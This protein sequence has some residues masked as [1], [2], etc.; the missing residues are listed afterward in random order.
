MESISVGVDIGSAAIKV[1]VLSG[2]GQ[3]MH[4]AYV[5]HHYRVRETLRILWRQ[6]MA[7]VREGALHLAFTGKGAAE[8]SSALQIPFVN[9]VQAE[10]E[11]LRRFHPEVD[12]A[13][14]LGGEDARMMYFERN[15]EMDLR[16]NRKCA[17]GT[18]TFLAHMA[19]FFGVD[20][21]ALNALA[22]NGIHLYPIA[23]RC[24]VYA[25]TDIQALMN[26]GVGK[27]D[28]AASIFQAVV[29]QVLSDLA[30][31]RLIQGKLA[32]LGG[33]FAFMPALR[34]SFLQTIGISSADVLPVTH[35]ELYCAWGAA[36][37]G[38]E[39]AP[40]AWQ[41]VKRL[42]DQ[43][44]LQEVAAERLEP[45]FPDMAAYDSFRCYYQ[46]FRLP[47]RPMPQ[48][49]ARLWLGM[50]AGSTTIKL[51]LVDEEGQIC[52]EDY[53]KNEADALE[54]AKTMLLAMYK[55]LPAGISIAASGIT[56][57]GEAFL[58]Q[59]FQID[60]GE[61][62]TVAHL[63]GARFFCPEVTD[64]LDIGGQDMKYIRVRKGSIQKIVLNGS[65]ASGCGLFLETFAE[66][67]GL[68]MDEFVKKAVH[69]PYCQDLG[70]HCTVLMNSK[71]HQVQN[72][73]VD[74]GGLISGLC[75][76]VV[77]NALY[78]V[79]RLDSIEEL[80]SHI[81][82][83]GG[84]FQNDAVLRAFETLVGHPV[85][86]PNGSGI[87][88][89]YGMALLTKKRMPE[90]ARSKMLSADE[91]RKLS[92]RE[93]SSRCP[94]CGNHCLLQKKTFSNGHCFIVGNRCSYGERLLAK[95][96]F[97][98]RKVLNLYEWEKNQLLQSSKV[99]PS[100]EKT[101][102]IPAVLGR[103]EDM[104]YWK[105]FWQTLGYRVILSAFDAA[106]LGK[107]TVT[108]PHGIYCYPCRLAH[109]HL[110]YFLEQ[111][112]PDGI[113][114]PVIKGGK[115]E[116]DIDEATHAAYGDV[117]AEQMKE[118]ISAA[119]IPFYHPQISFCNHQSLLAFMRENLPQ[120]TPYAL[121]HAT[122]AA[123]KAQRGYKARLGKKTRDVLEWIEREKKNALV[124]VGRSYQLD[125]EIN[126]GIPAVMAGLGIPVLSAEGL[127]L[128]QN[129]GHDTL[130]FRE[131]ALFTAEMVCTNPYLH[132][133]QLQSTSCG[134]DMTTID[135]VQKRLERAGKR[136]T[137]ISLDQGVSTG[138]LQIRIRSLMA[139]IQEKQNR[140]C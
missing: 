53:R 76:S 26:Q 104:I 11:A 71:V 107:S 56:G 134:W 40:I 8:F 14:S 38:R 75:L 34:R 48:P 113:W 120:V 62:E 35:G 60:T 36:L 74:T 87:M 39:A 21:Q 30:K 118:Q 7:K 80:G 88:G 108:M 128:L 70:H 131:K 22:E 98:S 124:L 136:Y 123:E 10:T 12:V 43:D 3:L 138:A 79:M 73:N 49:P 103:W 20:I 140:L 84:T 139:E 94:G 17:G 125:P 66:S 105:V 112:K 67:M 89:A 83:E 65:C 90:A 114:M 51:V 132:F 100:A 32:L 126:K 121:R 64:L 102:G 99:N 68:S 61:V 31:G 23:S 5:P 37:L 13:V 119:G 106:S 33:P 9:E 95:E 78:R 52:Y 72:E 45:L 59:A 137:M 57:Y 117:L 63:Q 129:E 1:V 116:P 55:A 93:E 28:L 50:D 92:V 115:E 111:C 122:T 46:R 127:Y 77:K 97:V 29:N 25:K 58:K 4:S 27:A 2:R 109:G 86:R 54:T 42:L 130:T 19:A 91:I 81:V 41:D 69:A 135:A 6:L 44:H 133:V 24:G 15:G 16:T 110:M 96:H 85:V 18:G 82:V 47:R 101:M